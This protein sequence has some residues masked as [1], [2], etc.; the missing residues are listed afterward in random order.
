MNRSLSL[1]VRLVLIAGGAVLVHASHALFHTPH[2]WECFLFAVLAILTGSFTIDIAPVKASISVADTFFIA[3]ALL[4]GPAPAAIT[5]AV[6]TLL[7]SWRKKRGPMRTAFNVVA[8]A[9]SL[10]VAAHVFF[11]IAGVAPL[12]SARVPIPPLITPLLCLT[13][14]YFVLNSGFIAI[15]VGLEAQKSPLQIWRSHFMWLGL[16]YF[17]AASVALCLALI[18][19]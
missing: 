17:A 19:Q 10:W 12:S 1:Y 9:V 6:D 7:L 5:L 18:V 16:G 3:S 2:P 15:A 4:F 8:P 13:A 14:I 11:L